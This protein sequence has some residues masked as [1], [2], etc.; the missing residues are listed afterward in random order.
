MM[1]LNS[2]HPNGEQLL[3]YADG[4]LTS[5]EVPAIRTH[6]EACWQCRAELEEFHKTIN[7]CVRYRKSVLETHLPSPPAPWGDLHRKFTEAD[8]TLG[9]PS[10]LAQ[11]RAS[12]SGM[13]ISPRKWATAGLLLGVVV[14]AA[15][16]KLHMDQPQP[17]P[18]TA[19]ADRPHS[20]AAPSI[21]NQAY[22]AA[23]ALSAPTLP[24]PTP[25]GALP[26]IL[27]AA[28]AAD[29]L[30][31]FV[32]LHLV[33]ADLGEPVQVTRSE[34]RVHVIGLGIDPSRQARILAALSAIP[35]LDIRFT[36]PAP[37][38]S[39]AE[40][41][42]PAGTPGSMAT[43]SGLQDQ[44]LRHLGT[45][46]AFEQFSNQTLERSENLMARAFAI[47]RLAQRFPVEVESG[48]S[49][50][51]RRMLSDLRGQHL[52]AL[53]QESEQIG[54]AALS[55][56]PGASIPIA[57]SSRPASW[58][59]AAEELFRGSQQ[60]ERSLAIALGATPGDISAGRLFTNIAQLNGSIEANRLLSP[61]E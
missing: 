24:M 51:E 14:A 1:H 25:N 16:F 29:E 48:L 22:P 20:T 23:P 13:F 43:A 34:G 56:V 3:R 36:E 47:R 19:P 18:A 52:S 21:S 26:A 55:V 5:A 35:N 37:A 44:I 2:S 15:T 53:N 57:Q 10:L 32:A 50:D 49:A 45:R 6:L 58:Q 38:A 54:R 30:R 9:R 40:D 4:E 59:A 7:E 28:T 17:Q 42:I 12:L 60:L 41:F 8:A 61:Q 46:T 39:R 31:V 11:W 33:G 27:P